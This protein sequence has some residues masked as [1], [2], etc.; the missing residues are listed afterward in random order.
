MNFQNK[1][2]PETIY[3]ITTIGVGKDSTDMHSRCVG[4]FRDL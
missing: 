2:T 1:W 4:W 3:T